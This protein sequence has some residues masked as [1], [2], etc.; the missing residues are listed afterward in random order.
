MAFKCMNS[1]ETCVIGIVCGVLGYA[2][3][4]ISCSRFGRATNWT[5]SRTIVRYLWYLSS[6]KE[7]RGRVKGHGRKISGKFFSNF[8]MPRV[9]KSTG[10]PFLFF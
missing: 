9:H 10:Y 1:I 4:W 6:S 3:T 2:Y 8:L 7:Y 5:R